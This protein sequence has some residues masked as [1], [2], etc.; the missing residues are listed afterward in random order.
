MSKHQLLL[1][2][3]CFIAFI[4]LGLPDGLLGISWPYIYKHYGVSLDSLGLLLMFFTAGYLTASINSG[5]VMSKMKLGTLLSLSCAITGISLLG[6]AF[7]GDWIILL[8]MAYFLGLGG[9]AIDASI[10]TFAA[11]N[12]STSVVNWLHAFYGVGATLGPLITTFYLIND[13]SWASGYITVAFIQIFLSILFLLTLKW[14][15]NQR[16]EEEAKPMTRGKK[17]LSLRSAWL[18]IFIFFIYTGTEISVGQ[19]LFTILTKSRML[20]EATAGIWTSAYWGSLTAGR[21]VFGFIM[22]K[23]SVHKVLTACLGG[24]VLGATL[25]AINIFELSTLAGIVIIGISVAPIF[26]S[27]IAMTPE[28]VGQNHAANVVGYQISAAMLGGALLPGFAGLMTDY[29]SIEVI[30]IIHVVEAL[31]LLILYLIISKKY[32]VKR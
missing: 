8:V 25:I 32:P 5:Y 30:N 28:R 7:S 17:T 15:K 13:F 31:V 3:I 26:P 18:S 19:W 24:I 2:L 16:K 22:V 6:Y 14:W 27:L 11:S 9:G 12:F 20:P 21:I 10:N 29:F 23:F 4:S 1:I